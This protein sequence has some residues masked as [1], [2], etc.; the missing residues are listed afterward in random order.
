M[1]FIRWLFRYILRF[2]RDG[3]LPDDRRVLGQLYREAGFWHLLELKK[4]I[5]DEKVLN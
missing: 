3:F 4:A 5:E 1:I 2:L